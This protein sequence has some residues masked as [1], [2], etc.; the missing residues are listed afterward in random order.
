MNLAKIQKL[1][2]DNIS[3]KSFLKIQKKISTMTNSLNTP[4]KILEL[5]TKILHILPKTFI[6]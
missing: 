2:I 6:F 5:F 3:D 4:I 1:N